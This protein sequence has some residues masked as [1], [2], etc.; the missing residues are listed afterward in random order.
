MRS[1]YI[2]ICIDWNSDSL[3]LPLNSTIAPVQANALK[4][5]EYQRC[6]MVLQ[7]PGLEI[8][9]LPIFLFVNF[10]VST[11]LC[12][13]CQSSRI[14]CQILPWLPTRALSGGRFT[15]WCKHVD[16]I[17]I[18]LNFT[19]VQTKPCPAATQTKPCQTKS[20]WH[21]NQSKIDNLVQTC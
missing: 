21:C 3:W 1:W 17:N 19:P 9:L 6:P 8:N 14:Y 4:V 18:Q 12:I 7:F 13:C 20:G 5:F 16:A 2:L 10:Q 15:I 11:D